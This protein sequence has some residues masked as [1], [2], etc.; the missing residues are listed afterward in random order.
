[1]PAQTGYVCFTP[2]ERTSSASSAASEKCTTRVSRPITTTTDWVARRANHTI[3][4]SSPVSKNISVFTLPK[5]VL[6][7]SPSRLATRGVSGSSSTLGWD[8]VDAAAF[9]AQRDC[10]AGD[11]PVSDQQ[12]ADE[13]CCCVRRS[14]VVLTPRRWRQVRG[15]CVG[16]TGRGYNVGS[17]ATVAKE[18]GRR[19]EREISRKTIAC[20]NA[21]RFRCTRCYSCAFY[22]YKCTRGRGCNGRPA[23]PTPSRGREIHQRLGRVARRGRGRVFGEY[24]CAVI[25]VKRSD[26]SPQ[27][28]SFRDAPSGAGPE[29]RDSG[30]DASHRPGMTVMD[31][32]RSLFTPTRSL[33]MTVKR[34]RHLHGPAQEN[35]AATLPSPESSITTLSPA[36]SQIVLTRL[37]VSTI[38]PAERPLPS[39]AR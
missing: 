3:G 31:C 19:G 8:A 2:H 35:V 12:H 6:E 33:A 34:A 25:F 4:R 28:P 1:M 20:G 17:R 23:F 21:G 29:S 39:E 5:S 32:T 16:P 26:D 24:E 9:C 11:E 13:R 7:A 38:S 36:V 10:R 14:R 30:F 22:H 27:A 37:P 18:P 15:C